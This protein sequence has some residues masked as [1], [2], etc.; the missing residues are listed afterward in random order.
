MST[1][2]TIQTMGFSMPLFT[3]IVCLVILL[4]YRQRSDEVNQHRLIWITV[5]AN[6]T[7]AVIWLVLTLYV[8][9]YHGF[10][11]MNTLFFFCLMLNQVLLYLLVY[12]ITS[13]MGKRRI[14]PIHYVIPAFLAMAM[15]VWSLLTPYEVQYSIV[16]SRG[17]N[18]PGYVWY[19]RYFSATVPIFIIYNIVYPF[20]SF[21]RI[22]I[23]RQVVVNYSADES[24][25]SASWLYQL[26]FLIM[27]PLPLASATLFMHKSV[28]FSSW[29]T[30]VG[31]FLPTFQ[32]LVICYNLMAG[33][34]VI[35]QPSD[36][37]IQVGTDGKKEAFNRARL[38]RYMREKK[39]YLNP[40]LK[41]IDLCTA[42]GTNRSY[43][44]AFINQEYRMNFSQYIN[45]LRLKELDRLRIS[46]PKGLDSNMELVLMA[47]FSSYR[48][49]RRAKEKEDTS[50]VLK[51]FE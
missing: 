8:V 45:S 26:V 9:D 14:H 36:E 24:R 32:Y 33:N 44:S 42:L 28:M 27:L 49:Y 43:L 35:I 38:E 19:S 23:Y 7:A 22:R 13:T 12:N 20:L 51:V 15:G 48:S 37:D 30:L 50:R 25:A 6:A 47:G 10:V 39:P 29:L 31:A 40:K 4:M 2:E 18:V 17:E 34:Y 21:Y 11:Y 16:E 5:W 41:I 3:A 46:P 1:I